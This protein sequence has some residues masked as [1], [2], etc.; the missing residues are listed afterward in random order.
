MKDNFMIHEREATI[1]IVIDNFNFNFNFF[2]RFFFLTL[3][4]KESEFC[5]AEKQEEKLIPRRSCGRKIQQNTIW[6]NHN[7]TAFEANFIARLAV[8]YIYR[9][10]LTFGIENNASKVIF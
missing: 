6:A 5:W 3:L 7:T 2:L 9:R 8:I 1:K 4:L 10:E